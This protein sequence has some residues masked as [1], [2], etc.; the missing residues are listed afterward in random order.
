MHRYKMIVKACVLSASLL[1]AGVSVAHEGGHEHDEEGLTDSSVG[2]LA[3]S[4]L[5][6]LV[7]AKKVA[8]QWASAKRDSVAQQKVAGKSVWVVTYKDP[9]AKVQSAEGTLYVFF[10]DFGNLLEANH[11]G[12]LA[13][14]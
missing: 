2:K 7:Q 13:A 3:D 14:K 12:K 6:K 5:P 1:F 4:S 11:T 10:D 9:A 8:P